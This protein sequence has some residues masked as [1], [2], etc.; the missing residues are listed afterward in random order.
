MVDKAAQSYEKKEQE[1]ITPDLSDEQKDLDTLQTEVDTEVDVTWLK[2]SIENTTDKTIL[3][4]IEWTV[5]HTKLKE[6][7][8]SWEIADFTIEKFAKDINTTVESYLRESFKISWSESLTVSDTVI[9]SMSIGIQFAMMDALTKSWSD[10]ADFFTSFSKTDTDDASST[11][12]GLTKTFSSEWMFGKL[13]GG[14]GKTNQFYLLANKVESCITFITRYC[15]EWKTLGDWT[16]VEKIANANEFRKLFDNPLW[17][18][19]TALLSKTPE[20]FGLTASDAAVGD[21]SDTDKDELKNIVN[22]EN[23]PINK[24]TV[25]AIMKSLPTAQ[26]FLKKRSGYKD[27]AVDIM[28]ALTKIFNKDVFWLGTIGSIIG[29]HNPLELFGGKDGK[30]KWGVVNFVLRIMWFQNGMEEL[31]KESINRQLTLTVEGKQFITDTLADYDTLVTGWNAATKTITALGLTSLAPDVQAKIPTEYD[32]IKKALYTNITKSDILLDPSALASMKIE[33]DT[34]EKDADGKPIIKYD[35][36]LITED[37]VAVYLKTTI[38]ALAKNKDFITGIKTSDEFMLSLTGW[39][40]YG[41]GT[42]FSAAV[43][44]GME[45][46]SKYTENDVDNT[47]VAYEDIDETDPD[48]VDL[49]ATASTNKERNYA[50]TEIFTD[51]LHSLEAKNNLP[52]GIMINLMKAES[53]GKL[54][55]ADGTILWSSA[56]AQWLFQFMPS[57]AKSYIVKLWYAESDYE[58][59]FTNPVIGAKACAMLLKSNIDDGKNTINA[60]ACYNRWAGGISAD[61]WGKWVDETT[62]SN[63]PKETQRYVLKIGYDMLAYSGKDTIITAGQK[64]DPTLISQE[65]LKEFFVA[66]NAISPA[67]KK[68]EDSVDSPEILAK[69][70]DDAVLVG[71]SHAE[72]ISIM[73]WFK[74]KTLY[75]RGRDSG[76]LLDEI[77]KQKTDIQK[78]K[79]LILVTWGND[80]S[81]WLISKVKDNLA[82]I[83]E[84]ISPVQL[85]L[86]TLSYSNVKTLIPDDQVDEFNA[87]IKTFAKE[88]S[89]PVID[90]HTD[91]TMATADY[92][93]D[94]H[95]TTTGYTKVADE[96][97]D[98]VVSA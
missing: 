41:Y 77:K 26:N 72:W 86:T 79:S 68:V 1:S 34:S 96:I 37:K 27:K 73:W 97:A 81:K 32:H 23:M 28:W 35:K 80:I 71:D 9:S 57:T 66:V 11:F 47:D 64:S 20:D 63:I 14:V 16:K 51:Y 88:H 98:R 87:I 25:E 29:I 8:N 4:Y 69:N 15:G 75:Y 12:T 84:E 2:N 44:L 13:F 92:R 95:Y 46:I 6:L 7:E 36:T 91:V 83:Q 67:N 93:S 53:G 21:L 54:Y 22:N 62:L 48:L 60:L 56:D 18:D 55:A 43:A 3:T 33:V 17:W 82:A 74:G 70:I 59:I 61:T 50:E 85:V 76:Q 40:I 90:I 45:P 10:G 42:C 78:K 5:M 30:K 38:P 19:S 31:Y 39:M 94:G 49:V 24:K 58:K 65:K 89:L 52:Y